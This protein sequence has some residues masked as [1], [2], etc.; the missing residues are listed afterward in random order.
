MSP[1]GSLLRR[2]YIILL[3]VADLMLIIRW[4][5]GDRH[6]A[7][8]MFGSEIV[9]VLSLT[10]A[11][12][13]ADALYV[14]C[15]GLMAFVSG[16]LDLSIAVVACKKTVMNIYM[17]HK[18]PGVLLVCAVV[19]LSGS[20][21]SYLLIR[22]IEGLGRADGESLFL[23]NDNPGFY[24]SIIDNVDQHSTTTAVGK[25]FVGKPH[26]LRDIMEYQKAETDLAEKR[27]P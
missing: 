4:W 12:D 22:E 5:L 16:I 6:G 23:T 13:G 25:P 7:M 26:K 8:L 20:F 27:L 1:F 10:V 21:A 19:Q 2:W 11:W 17:F 3:I 18:L 24:S 15:Y 14:G 9:G